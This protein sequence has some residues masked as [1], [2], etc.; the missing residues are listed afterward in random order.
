M[1][2][3]ENQQP[4]KKN[5]PNLKKNFNQGDR[6]AIKNILFQITNISNRQIIAKAIGEFNRQKIIT[7]S[8]K[9]FGPDGR[10]IR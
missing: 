2:I 4:E 1:K 10:P 3:I 8:S 7:P 9:L 5:V 6:F